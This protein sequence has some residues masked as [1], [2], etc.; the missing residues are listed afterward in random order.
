M[1]PWGPWLAWPAE[2]PAQQQVQNALDLNLAP[3]AQQEVGI[4]LNAPV[5][6]MEVTINPINPPI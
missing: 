4:D 1:N 3:M 2:I 5:D 6:P